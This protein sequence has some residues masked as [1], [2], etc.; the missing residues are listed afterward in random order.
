MFPDRQGEG[1]QL[2][3]QDQDLEDQQGEDEVAAGEGLVEGDVQSPLGD[4]VDDQEGQP[5][6][7]LPVA[8]QEEDQPLDQQGQAD[9]QRDQRHGAG[10]GLPA[11]DGAAA[12]VEG[13]NVVVA[14]EKRLLDGVLGR[15]A[16]ELGDQHGAVQCGP[17]HADHVVVEAV[18]GFP[19]DLVLVQLDGRQFAALEL[20]VEFE[21]LRRVGDDHDHAGCLGRV[22]PDR[23]RGQQE[24]GERE[25]QREDKSDCQWAGGEGGLHAGSLLT[26]RVG[27]G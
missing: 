22:R 7:P 17:V 23:W 27:E 26:G 3:Q 18:L 21:V 5:A 12:G 16:A 14:A 13:Q 8:E 20:Q 25:V 6:A 24:Q 19:G 10:R 2:D 9:A 4:Q 11:G 1:D 15:H